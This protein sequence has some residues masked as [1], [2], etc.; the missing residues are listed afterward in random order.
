[1]EAEGP[2]GVGGVEGFKVIPSRFGHEPV[3]I[4]EG[5]P[6]LGIGGG[7]EE[8]P[9]VGVGV[10]VAVWVAERAG[11]NVLVGVTLSDGVALAL[12]VSVSLALLPGRP[13]G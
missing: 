6:N 13:R 7:V 2:V 4:V 12:G 1:M 10:R 11:L 3:A 9:S 5:D 8:D